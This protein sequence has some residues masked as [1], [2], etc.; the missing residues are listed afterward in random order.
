MSKF[1]PQ[2]LNIHEFWGDGIARMSV[3]ERPVESVYTCAAG[4]SPSGIVHFGNFR[5]VITSYAVNQGLERIGKKTRLIFSW[6]NF[7]RLRKVPLGVPES[8]SQ[9]IGKPLSKIPDPFG[10]FSSYAERFQQPFVDAMEKLGIKLE[11]LD[12]TKLYESGV[13]DKYII[14]ALQKRHEIADILSSF[15]TKKGIEDRGLDLED[16]REHYYPISIYSRFTGKDTTQILNYDGVSS[17]TYRCLETNKED[18]VDISK[19]HIAKLGWKIDWAMRWMH[20]NVT[21]EPGGHDH[22]SPGS[23]YD[24]SNE[25]VQ[26]IFGFKAPLFAEYKFIGIQGL[27]SKMSGSKGNAI[28]PKDLLELYD[29][30]MLK[31][32]YLRKLPEQSFM[33]AFDS[34]IYR[35]YDEFDREIIQYQSET[36]SEDVKTVFRDSIGILT[37]DSLIEPIPFRQAVGFGQIMQWNIDKLS[38]ILQSSNLSYGRASLETRIPRARQWLNV[39]NINEKFD[40]LKTPNTV[41]AQTLNDV[42]KSYI[43]TLIEQLSIR[44]DQ[45]VQELE[46]LVYN[47]PK[48]NSI[49]EVVLKKEQRHFFS[50]IYKLLIGKDTGPRLGTFLWALDRDKVLFLLKVI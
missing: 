19:E 42:V 15:M 8:F 26:K 33:L 36:C 21:F 12:Q 7:D 44:R 2:K 5:D 27:G 20:E 11:Y 31:W 39:Y 37:Q 28:S 47:I 3:E 22:A 18:T 4:I 13:Y 17:I 16:Y 43:M 9:H 38:E 30:I 14:L 50:V 34:E 46:T 40:L 45:T 25:I 6:D 41:Y 32:L 23:S 1:D 35:Q 48:K 10:E 24:T 29:P 49:G